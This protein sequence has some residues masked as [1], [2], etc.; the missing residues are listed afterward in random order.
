MDKGFFCRCMS[1]EVGPSPY[2]GVECG[3][4]PVGRGRFVI[5]DDL[6]DVR[7]ERFDVLLRWAC[8]EL[9]IVLTDMLSEKV[10]SL[11]RVRYVGFLF[12]EFQSS[13]PQK[14]CDEGFDFFFQDLFRD[15][16]DDEV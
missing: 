14:L 11:L 1:V 6:S 7:Q 2:V 13:F 9:P 3:D 5:L 4:Q 10:K 8:K 15:P 12:R 16:C